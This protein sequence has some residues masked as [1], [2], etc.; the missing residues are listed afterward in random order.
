MDVGD[1]FS[2]GRRGWVRLHEKGGKE[3]EAPCI[4][5]LEVYLDEYIA[6]AGIAGDKGRAAVPHYGALDR[7]AAPDD[8]AGCLQDAKELAKRTTNPYNRGSSRQEQTTKNC[9]YGG[10]CFLLERSPKRFYKASQLYYCSPPR[11]PLRFPAFVIQ[12][13]LLK[14]SFLDAIPAW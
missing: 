10:R 6:A 11:P 14:P 3:H 5:K 7:H 12:A 8:A 4:P 13:Y 2:Q 1:Y 9:S